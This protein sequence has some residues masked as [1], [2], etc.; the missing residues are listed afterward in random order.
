MLR[1]FL[2]PPNWFTSASIF[3]GVY[4]IASLISAGEPTPELLVHVCILVLF[5]AVFDLLD[6]RVAR[7]TNRFSEFGVQLDSLADLITFGVAP[8]MLAWTWKLHELGRLG[9]VIAF[10]YVLC[11]AFRLARFNVNAAHNAWKL[12]GHSQGLTSTMS[13]AV[14]VVLVWMANGY[15]RD[16][17]EIPVALAGCFVAFLGLMMVSSVPMRSF[18]DIRKNPRARAI[19]AGSLATCL[20]AAVFLD[21]S[22]WFGVGALLYVTGGLVDGLVTAFHFRSAGRVLDTVGNENEVVVDVGDDEDEEDEE[23]DVVV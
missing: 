17:V 9:A 8:A 14:L 18:R 2:N 13:G 1:H 7:M 3:C 11:A 10:W 15:L 16:R 5:G 19:L 22:M 21:P 23:A 6:G 20:A 12:A 4:A